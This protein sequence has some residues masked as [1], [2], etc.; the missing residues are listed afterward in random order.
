MK[1]IIVFLAMLLAVAQLHAQGRVA[2]LS[3]TEL[4]NF[5]SLGN[6]EKTALSTWAGSAS[7]TTL[8]TV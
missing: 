1:K 8:G 7:L 5:Q 6:V 2:G 4:K 3:P